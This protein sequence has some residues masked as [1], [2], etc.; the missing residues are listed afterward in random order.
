MW[1]VCRFFASYLAF[2]S[3]CSCCI[4]CSF[5]WCMALKFALSFSRI[6]AS[7]SALPSAS[8]TLWSKRAASSSQLGAD[9]GVATFLLL[10]GPG[11]GADLTAGF[12]DGQEQKKEGAQPFGYHRK[13]EPDH[14]LCGQVLLDLLTLLRCMLPASFHISK[15]LPQALDF[16]HLMLALLSVLIRD[17]SAA[18]L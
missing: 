1:A 15:L 3:S 16:G 18:G 10:P 17:M 9:S 13:P 4:L 11:V 12:S 7:R 2:S 5:L 14:G 6:C 8:C